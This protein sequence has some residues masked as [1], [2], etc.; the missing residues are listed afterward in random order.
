[1]D[2]AIMQHAAKAQEL[3]RTV[4]IKSLITGDLAMTHYSVDTVLQCIEVCIPHQAWHAAISTLSSQQDY[5]RI[6]RNVADFYHPYK[7]FAAVFEIK[8]SPNPLM[9]IV[10]DLNL[11][12]SLQGLPAVLHTSLN[13][14]KQAENAL[15]NY[16]PVQ[17]SWPSLSSFVAVWIHL[18]TQADTAEEKYAYMAWADRLIGSNRIDILWCRDNIPDLCDTEVLSILL[19]ER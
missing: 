11:P 2:S 5:S 17:I 18:A 7:R 13:C 1:M 14:T 4:G 19:R 15:S 10:D 12:L 6:D 16:D 9:H 3:L 8:G